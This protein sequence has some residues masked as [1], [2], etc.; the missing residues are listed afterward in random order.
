MY[1]RSRLYKLIITQSVVLCHEGV[2]CTETIIAKA[3][4]VESLWVS[5]SRKVVRWGY[6]NGGSVGQGREVQG[7]KCKCDKRE[8]DRTNEMLSGL[9]LY[10]VAG[11]DAR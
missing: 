1:R 3:K 10:K 7:G 2:D 4:Q 6:E 11:W 5:G 8:R 9:D